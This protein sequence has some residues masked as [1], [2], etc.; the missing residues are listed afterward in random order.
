MWLKMSE[1]L[2]SALVSTYNSEKFIRGCLEDL[3]N[4]TL[5]KKN[6]LE[7]I[8]IDAN[9]QQNE[10]AIVEEFKS[11]YPNII[12]IRTPE[13]I[14]LY[15]AWNVGIKQSRGKYLTNANTDDRHHPAALEILANELEKYPDIALVYPDQIV[16]N[17]ENESFEKFTVAGFT[18]YPEFDRQ[19]LL[20]YTYIGHQPMWRASLHKEFG[21]FS[22][23]LKV[24]GDYEWWLRISEKYD[25]KHIPLLLGLYY[26]NTEGL[27][28]ENTQLCL[29]ETFQVRQF[30]QK[31]ANKPSLAD[32]YP[33]KTYFTS[34][35]DFTKPLTT[36]PDVSFILIA[37]SS[38]KSLIS[39]INSALNQ[40]LKNIEVIVISNSKNDSAF[41][42][43]YYYDKR[44]KVFD[45]SSSLSYF[46]TLRYALNIAQGRFVSILT[47]ETK[48]FP[49][50]LELSLSIL[51]SNPHIS[52]VTNGL[53]KVKLGVGNK[54]YYEYERKKFLFKEVIEE[55][56]KISKE[57]F[58]VTAVF[59]KETLKNEKNLKL[60]CSEPEFALQSIPNF[61][62]PQITWEYLVPFDEKFET[63]IKLYTEQKISN[64]TQRIIDPSKPPLVSVIIPCY[65][66][67]EFLPEAVESVVKQTFTDW[68]C[69]IVNDGSTDNTR[70]VAE[71]LR[72]KYP[73][74]RILYFEKQNE[75]VAVARNFG[76]SKSK[77]KYILPLDADDLIEPTFLEKAV[78]ILETE[79]DIA[80]VYT[81]VL[82]F[83]AEHRIY[84]SCN[85]NALLEVN[86]NYIGNSSLYR[87]T[88][89][90]K[91]GG[92]KSNLGY[93]DWEFWINAI[94][95]GFK[96]KRIPEVLYLY[97]VRTLSR[98]KQDLVKDK[99]NK[100]QI[101]KLHPSLY[102]SKQLQ[103]AEYV[104][105]G[106]EFP[107]PFNDQYCI[108]PIF[109][110]LN[111]EL[112]KCFENQA[113]T[114]QHKIANEIQNSYSENLATLQ[115]KTKSHPNLYPS[116]EIEKLFETSRSD[117]AQKLIIEFLQQN[118]SIIPALND[119]AISF[120]LS[121]KEKEALNLLQTILIID[122]NNQIAKE[123]LELIQNKGT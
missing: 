31:K 11:K 38:G 85:W 44:V 64:E 48:L 50:H 9:S 109:P 29:T 58:F 106:K 41:L 63:H 115:N 35:I 108:M 101:I 1:I 122:P 112:R 117:E 30:Y 28:R 81:D 43:N 15:A 37:R 120:Y 110:E 6:L 90:E 99:L 73:E 40:T 74:R 57:F 65:N 80:I 72:Q 116:P 94:E 66:L 19:Y 17:K 5:F 118:D 52:F 32:F 16:T 87:K 103:W 82:H 78:K 97:R 27:E 49:R 88:V 34:Y 67:A 25:F 18:S 95:Q 114:S 59:Q 42:K 62:I 46:D 8:V 33:Q 83:G 102:S 26:Y 100:A 55:I 23:K 91:G 121:G 51:A 89:W 14:P 12:Y 68:E 39:T 104:L 24:A 92:Y 61:H 54:T 45:I 20:N 3:V 79:Q 93:E 60:I 10:K 123:N 86:M 96:G 13:R 47:D 98:F 119:L 71:S 76:I 56:K 107:E 2:V 77:G 70:Q 69:I 7:I 84:P 75:G 36:I 4:Q 113:E 22:D 21:F 105:G 53:F 111:L